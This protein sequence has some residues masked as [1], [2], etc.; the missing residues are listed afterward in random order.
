MNRPFFSVV[1]PTKNRPELLRDAISSVLFQNF[2]D[3]ELIV[4]DNFNDRQTYEVVA[5][6]KNNSHLKYFRTNSELNMPDHWE[7]ATLK[8]IGKYVLVLTD[9]SVLKQGTL[10]KIFNIIKTNKKVAV[11]SWNW[12]LFDNKRNIVFGDFA[13]HQGDSGIIKIISKD[14][15]RYFLGSQQYFSH[16]LPRGLN[17]CYRFDVAE[18]IR[19]KYGRLFMPIS[20]DFTSAFLFLSQISEIC[21]IDQSL[22]LSQG[23]EISNGE[24]SVLSTAS[25]RLYLKTLKNIDCYSYVPIKAP[26]VENLI[27]DD[28]LKIQKLAGGNLKNLEID[29]VEYFVRNYKELLQKMGSRFIDRLTLTNLRLEFENALSVF[30]NK[31]QKEVRKRMKRLIFLMFKARIKR[32]FLGPFSIS[33]KRHL[34][35]IIKQTFRDSYKNVLEAAGFN[36]QNL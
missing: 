14:L 22:F 24:K 25:A 20:P 17:S 15:I 11:Y 7:W 3:Y 19:K 9:R 18:N 6:F 32:S 33:F 23:L 21:Y 12:A 28:F 34:E 36:S 8:T 10:N 26:I 29:W 35:F 13:T 4:S 2:D 1:I 27:F 16:G 5:E 31:T 30:D